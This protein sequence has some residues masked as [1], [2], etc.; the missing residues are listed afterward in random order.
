VTGLAVSLLLVSAASAAAQQ[1][2]ELPRPSQPARVCT[3][4]GQ[5]SLPEGAPASNV[6]VTLV[7]RGGVPRQTYANE[8]G[9]FEFAG[10][11]EGAYSLS[12]KSLTDPGLSVEGVE[13]DTTR[14]VTG[15]LNISLILRRDIT[16]TGVASKAEIV[17]AAEAEQKVPKA[18]RRAFRDAVKFRE[19]D[20]SEKA[21]ESLS[22]AVELYPDY[23]Q[24]FAERGDLLI[25]LHKL[26]DACKDFESALKLNPRYSPALRGAGYCKLEG[27]QFEEAAKYLE[28]SVSA[29]PVNPNAYL[30]LGIAYL[31]LDRR[32]QARDALLKALGFNT[33]REL[34]ARIYLGNLYARSGQFKEA[35]DELRKYLDENPDDPAAAELRE[36]ESKWRARAAP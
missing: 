5:V 28:Q 19:E 3:I 36:V 12:A 33:R 22:R 1:P 9:R 6:L 24:A 4:Q 11:P 31:E 8:H 25:A 10:I 30:L 16:P 18:A 23:F 15:D 35:A 7:Y 34:R 17:T 13:A 2:R 20:R 14:T 21:L 32:E 27:R 29:Q 26:A